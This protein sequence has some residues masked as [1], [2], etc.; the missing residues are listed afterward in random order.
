MAIHLGVILNWR[1]QAFCHSALYAGF[2]MQT[3]EILDVV[4]N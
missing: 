3:E 2:G 4:P 1:I